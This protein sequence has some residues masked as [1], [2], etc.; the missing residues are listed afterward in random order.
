MI[1]GD[2]L[3]M[4]FIPVPSTHLYELVSARCTLLYLAV[5]SFS[6]E[7]K[8]AID[9]DLSTSL[10]LWDTWWPWTCR[11]EATGNPPESVYTSFSLQIPSPTICSQPPNYAIIKQETSSCI[12]CDL[13]HFRSVATKRMSFWCATAGTKNHLWGCFLMHK[14]AKNSDVF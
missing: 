3:A 13:V 7:K 12:M 1:T 4:N 14:H 9:L 6:R 10:C 11:Y 5:E 8:F 2:K